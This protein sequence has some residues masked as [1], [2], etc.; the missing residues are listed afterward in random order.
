M[1]LRRILTRFLFIAVILALPLDLEAQTETAVEAATEVS[2]DAKID[3]VFGKLADAVSAVIFFKVLGFPIVLA[4]LIVAATTF[5][6]YFKF[7]NFRRFGLAV[8]IV[9]GRYAKPKEEGEVSLSKRSPR[10][11]PARWDSAISPE[12]RWR[13]R[14]AGRG[15]PSG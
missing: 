14:S 3:A 6:I 15:R 11:S 1:S 8:N 5:T 9:R 2:F 7:V 10:P 12:W 4:W 13:F